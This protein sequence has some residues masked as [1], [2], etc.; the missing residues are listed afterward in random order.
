MVKAEAVVLLPHCC[1]FGLFSE[2]AQTSYNEEPGHALATS[3]INGSRAC[4]T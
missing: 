3:W 1:K 2:P 4:L